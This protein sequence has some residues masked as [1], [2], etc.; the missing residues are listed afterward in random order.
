MAAK[1]LNIEVGDQIVKVCR[2]V[3]KGKCVQLFEP[4]MFP[5]PPGCVFD[6]LITDINV[7]AEETKRQLAEHQLSDVRNVI[8]SLMSGKIAVREV[9]LPPVKE[10]RL[11]SL[12]KTNASEYFPI[13]LNNYHVTHSLLEQVSGAEPYYRVLVMA[14]PIAL[15]EGY[16]QF[17]AALGMQVQSIDSSGNSHY[18][19]LKSIAN[20]GVTMYV[21]VDCTAS[22]ISFMLEDS[23]ALQRTFA[24]GGDDLIAHYMAATGKTPEEYLSA[25]D[26]LDEKSPNFA[27]D[28]PLTSESI[29]SDLKRLVGSI[30]RSVDY[31]NS[32]QWENATT[33]V[34]LMGPCRRVVGLREQIE[35]AT[36]LETS[37]LDDISEFAA[38]SKNAENAA[39][40]ISC[41]GSVFAPLDFMPPSLAESGKRSS[42]DNKDATIIPGVLICG[43]LIL[44]GILLASVSILN[45]KSAEQGLANT[46][47]EIADLEYTE[48]VYKTYLAYQKGEEAVRTVTAASGSPNSRLV[49]FYEELEAKM[50]ASIIVMSAMCTNEGV[51]MNVTVGSYE[52]AATAISNLRGF[53]SLANI[54]VSGITRSSNEA[55]IPR[56]EFSLNCTYGE[57]PYIN[58]INP[59][60]SLIS[61]PEDEANGEQAAAANPDPTAE[62]AQ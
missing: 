27:A 12:I 21:D 30:A 26:E 1:V 51:S 60:G 18:Q 13:D 2:A 9:K 43:L 59:Y 11:N 34:V 15:L 36:G 41:L 17:A 44:S 47:Q 7:L 40:Y 45:F 25:L 32:S 56:V 39:A 53:K 35:A 61:P 31:F 29:E 49:E 10:K 37:Y 62:E 50:P 20:K 28:L 14:A 38:L 5:T 58:G 4:F 54:E 23:L 42:V 57:N 33:R 3:R 46:K 55:G 48:T 16:F 24:F 52:D 8:F 22:F 6:G 19:A